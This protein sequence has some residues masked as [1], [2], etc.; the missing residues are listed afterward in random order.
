MGET[1]ALKSGYTGILYWGTVRLAPG[2]F[3]LLV[4]LLCVL[5]FLQENQVI[6][7]LPKAEE[8]KNF[9]EMWEED[10]WMRE[11]GR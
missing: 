11:P 8:N 2:L 6:I 1:I 7:T 5:F 10:E 4:R 9:P 3:L